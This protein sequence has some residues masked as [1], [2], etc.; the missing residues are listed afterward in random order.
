MI[1]KKWV[2]GALFSIFVI[3]LAGAAIPEP[4]NPLTNINLTFDQRLE[5]IKQ[6]DAALLKAT[7]EER[8]A[9]WHQTRDQMKALSPEDRKL[10]QEK[11]KAQWQSIT[12]EQKEKMKAERKAFFD[13]LTPEEQAEMKARRVKW[14]NMSPEEK[15]KWFKQPG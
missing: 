8:K 2:V 9:Y 4:P 6:I 10:V 1:S 3:S 12:P 7:P 13:G 11:M 14:E 5:Q 15:Q